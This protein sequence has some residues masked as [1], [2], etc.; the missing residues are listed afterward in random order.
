MTA[1]A[2]LPGPAAPMPGWPMRWGRRNTAR[3]RRRGLGGRG[4]GGRG[5]GDALSEAKTEAG[6]RPRPA[7]ILAPAGDGHA[8]LM[9]DGGLDVAER[10][11]EGAHGLDGEVADEVHAPSAVIAGAEI[12]RALQHL[13]CQPPAQGEAPE[14]GLPIQAA[15]DI[16]TRA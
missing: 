7:N 6:Q 11:R 16:K 1:K 15:L 13:M 14:P 10:G 9:R 3:V 5:V 12:G 4:L 2:A 8:M